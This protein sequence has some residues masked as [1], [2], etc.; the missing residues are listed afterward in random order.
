MTHWLQDRLGVAHPIIQAPMAGV[1]MPRM[2]AAVC[3]AG[4]LGSLGVGAASA[5]GAREM[6]QELQALT[7]QPFNINLFCHEPAERDIAVERRW[8]EALAPEFARFDA[9]VPEALEEIYKSF[10]V[11]DA[12]LEV[13][14]ETRPAVVSFHFGLPDAGRIAALKEAGCVLLASAN[15][16][17]SALACQ[18]A[19]VDAVVAQGIEA[20][21]HR[22]VFDPD[23]EDEAL[24]T[25]ALVAQLV[26][27]LEV[28]VIAAGGLMEGADIARVLGLGAVAAQLGT[29]FV[30]SYESAA[31]ADYRAAL[32]D[33]ACQPPVLTKTI[34]GRPARCLQNALVG[35]GAACTET[36]PAYP[37]TYDASK[38]L[39]AAAKK[40]GAAGYG[41][42]WAGSGAMRA[43]DG[44]AA[45]IMAQLVAELR[46]A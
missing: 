21:G 40:A 13:L 9:E 17:D 4:G 42:Q 8:L 46:A 36:V 15:S 25:E 16:V 22:G 44:G 7:A 5:E 33:P 11:D 32:R 19:G 26:G 43:R 27:V 2:A 34:S 14:L 6:I 38:A 20:G 37:V 39:M 45:E 31:D 12:M 18:A 30:A 1:S 35:W 41:A 24:G 3:A 29:A 28:P 10:L 23:A